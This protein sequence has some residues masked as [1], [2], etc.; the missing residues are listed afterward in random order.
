MAKREVEAIIVPRPEPFARKGRRG[1][2]ARIDALLAG[3]AVWLP[4]YRNAG[5]YRTAMKNLGHELAARTRYDHDTGDFIGTTI[6]CPDI[7]PEGYIP[8]EP[9][10]PSAE[11]YD[12][13]AQKWD[14]EDAR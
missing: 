12:A 13:M 6:W 4:G 1:N 7:T 11:E 14:E 2:S 10:E 9:R 3:R 8:P 5:Y